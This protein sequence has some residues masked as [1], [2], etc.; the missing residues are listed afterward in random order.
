MEVISCL[1]ELAW[2]VPAR[3]AWDELVFLPPPAEPHA[4]HWS[5][6]LGCI[7]GHT[8][9]LGS[10]LPP[11]WFCVSGPNSEFI[12]IAW[13]LLFEGSMLTYDPTTNRVKWVPV[14]GTTSD[15]SLVE[16]A[17]T[18]ELSNIVEDP[19]G[20]LED[21]PRMDCFEECKEGHG[22]EA[23]TD[24]FHLDAAL[25]EEESMEQA[26]QS[27]LGEEGSKSSKESDSSESTPLHYSSRCCHPDS[28]S[29]ADEDGEEGKEQEETEEKKQ[30]TLPASPH[31]E[32]KEEPVEE[33]P[34]LEQES[35][36]A[37]PT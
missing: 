30:P 37:V 29:W 31:G 8:V 28:V 35:P 3:K 26:P 16:E 14:Q 22:A 12:C 33:L 13:G 6:H 15:L 36:D 21:A 11:L 10:A 9:D 25:H 5:G 32:P 17:S 23:P 2:H 34:A 27:D 19:P 4:P 7:M 24:T 18:Q 1:D 20:P